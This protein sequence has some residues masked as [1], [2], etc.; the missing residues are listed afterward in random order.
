MPITNKLK[1]IAD[2]IRLKNG[3]TELMRIDQMDDAIR[4]LS[5]TDIPTYEGEYKVTP[6]FDP[7]VLDTDDKQLLE[8]IVI[9]PISVSE[10]GNNSNGKTLII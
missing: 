8:D 1:E 6:S 9:E 3:S 5:G 2:A 7:I 10:V 4:E